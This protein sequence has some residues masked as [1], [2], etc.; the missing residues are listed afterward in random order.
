MANVVRIQNRYT[1]VPMWVVTHQGLSDRA[2]VLYA[3]L[4]SYGEQAFPAR[5][6]LAKELNCSVSALDRA[7]NELRTLGILHKHTRHRN[8]GSQTT[9]VYVIETSPPATSDDPHGYAADPRPSDPGAVEGVLTREEGG[10]LSAEEGGVVS[11]DDPVLNKTDL[12][13]LNKELLSYDNNARLPGIEQQSEQ[14]ANM[15]YHV[16]EQWID[17]TRPAGEIS[18]S[19]KGKQLGII[20]RLLDKWSAE[21]VVRCIRSIA[22]E[23]WR[24]SAW[25]MGLVSNEID[26]RAAHG[27]PIASGQGQVSSVTGRGRTADAIERRRAADDDRA[28]EPRMGSSRAR[29]REES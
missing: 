16:Y 20:K 1:N 14:P 7:V 22:S 12:K 3:L 23:S 15:V 24:S 10:L 9:N 8:N 27:F 13:D 18:Q 6:T 17:A 21:D 2:K 28:P 29:Q 11:A 26:K 25:D 5:N 4:Y 19:Y